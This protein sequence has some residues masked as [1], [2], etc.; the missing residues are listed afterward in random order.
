MPSIPPRRFTPHPSVRVHRAADLSLT[1]NL[2]SYPLNLLVKNCKLVPVMLVGALVNKITYSR[3]DYAAVAI[4]S[5]GVLV[6][7]MKPHKAHADG[8]TGAG[9]AGL[10]GVLDDKANLLGTWQHDRMDGL[11]E[12][13][14][15]EVLVQS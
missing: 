15:E 4:I 14:L 13:G 6:F 11:R 12:E 7:M 8:P 1:Y 9:D 10:C 2:I 5:S 3:R